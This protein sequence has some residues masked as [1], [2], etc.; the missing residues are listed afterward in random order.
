MQR[1]TKIASVV[2]VLTLV[3]G[4]LA[5]GAP[6]TGG[7]IFACLAASAGSLTK[8]STKAPKCPRGTTLISW[9][10]VGPQ[11]QQGPAGAPGLPGQAG[12]NGLN[13]LTGQQGPQGL[14]GPM[15][16]QGPT[17]AQGPKGETGTQGP[18]G[19]Q[20]QQ[21]LQGP[22]G[23]TGAQGI[24]G[25]KGDQGVEGPRGP[26]GPSASPSLK[27]FAQT[28]MGELP[29]ADDRSFV[30]VNGVF[31]K[32]VP[33]VLDRQNIYNCADSTPDVKAVK[34]NLWIDYQ[35]D[36]YSIE[37]TENSNPNTRVFKTSNCTGVSYGYLMSYFRESFFPNAY[38]EDGEF[39]VKKKTDLKMNQVNS[40]LFGGKCVENS[41]PGWSTGSFRYR[42]KDYSTYVLDYKFTLVEMLNVQHPNLT[43]IEVFQEWR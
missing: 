29:I 3:T 5:L 36:G 43:F 10:Q 34:A 14:V 2:A 17:G 30:D 6:T 38:E 4:G 37:L 13:G 15:G 39:F 22:R 28:N 31:W 8:V 41:S 32:C 18:Q 33:F 40:Y 12:L 35:F 1:T 25:E 20:G 23:D 27:T 21:G 7:S 42:W 16:L 11:G 26:E 9:N 19:Q 24:K